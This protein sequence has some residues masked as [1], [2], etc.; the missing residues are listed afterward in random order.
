[1]LIPLLISLFA[2]FVSIYSYYN[3]SNK[4][5]SDSNKNYVNIDYMFI[6]KAKPPAEEDKRNVMYVPVNGASI[7]EKH[8]SIESQ[9]KMNYK[10]YAVN[11]SQ[12]DGT[13][14]IKIQLFN[15]TNQLFYEKIITINKTIKDWKDI[16]DTSLMMR[17]S[18]NITLEKL[19]KAILM[20][21]V[22]VPGDWALII[23]TF[24]LNI[25]QPGRMC[26]NPSF[27]LD[28]TT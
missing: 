25:E 6:T 23:S 5:E 8:I 27:G 17:Y 26:G 15:I 28:D 4:T 16:Y 18:G 14:I 19:D 21:I 1:M 22:A 7:F 9:N 24:S 10:F 13:S 3:I 11:Y 12:T 2:L 20:K